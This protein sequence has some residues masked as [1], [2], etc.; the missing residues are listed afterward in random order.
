MAA[1][2]IHIVVRKALSDIEQDLRRKYSVKTPLL[3]VAIEKDVVV[4]TFSGRSEG[5]ADE[6]TLA[7][8]TP[9]SVSTAETRSPSQRSRRRRKRRVRSRTKTRGWEIVDKFENSKGLNCTIY[10]PFYDSLKGKKL[11][12]R[13][14]Q[15]VVRQII[16]SNGSTPK[17]ATVDYYLD[18]T[19]EF[20]AKE[21]S[22]HDNAKNPREEQE[23][24]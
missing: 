13:E 1:D 5:R 16:L 14:A 20:L 12:R 6:L 23:A 24:A 21:N 3:D 22:P 10:K 2:E 17:P 8:S 11:R 18:N 4:F 15:A 7:A 9:T 19:L